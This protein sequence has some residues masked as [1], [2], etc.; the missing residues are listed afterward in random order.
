M[1]HSRHSMRGAGALTVMALIL[2]AMLV[3]TFVVKM[4]TQYTQY[5]T[6]RSIMQDVA[7]QPGAAE[8]SERELWREM[9]RRF[10]INSVYDGIE[11]DDFSV[12]ENG[13]RRQMHL[14]YE[15]RRE[16]IGNVDVVVRFSRSETLSP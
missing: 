11:E 6:V 13:D 4:G 1:R 7:A 12:T 3:G 10:Q 2:L 16:F 14:E 8:R 5:L 9:S 15:V